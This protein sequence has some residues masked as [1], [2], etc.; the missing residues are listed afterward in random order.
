MNMN[1][2]DDMAEFKIS[3]VHKL[4]KGD[5]IIKLDTTK[6]EN[7]DYDILINWYVTHSTMMNFGVIGS[8][9]EFVKIVYSLIS[10]NYIIDK[11]NDFIRQSDFYDPLSE[12]I[13]KVVNFED[14]SKGIQLTNLDMY[15]CLVLINSSNMQS[16]KVYEIWE[17]SMLATIYDGVN[18]STLKVDLKLDPVFVGNIDNLKNNIAVLKIIDDDKRIF[19]QKR[20]ARI[21]QQNEKKI[22]EMY[23][24]PH[25]L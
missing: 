10:G 2:K 15:E 9:K 23:Q 25:N 13:I 24:G 17:P 6:Y 11:I 12:K 5:V 21:H 19:D 20:Y 22:I 3:E 16:Y 14:P 8:N 1:I 18:F 4:T 7:V